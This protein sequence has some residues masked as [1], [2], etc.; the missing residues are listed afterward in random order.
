MERLPRTILIRLEDRDSDRHLFGNPMIWYARY[1]EVSFQRWTTCKRLWSRR[2]AAIV[3]AIN[4][5]LGVT[6]DRENAVAAVIDMVAVHNIVCKKW[7]GD[8]VIPQ[9]RYNEWQGDPFAWETGG[10]QFD[11]AAKI[12]HV[13]YT[14][15]RQIKDNHPLICD[16][17]FV[18]NLAK[19]LERKL[20]LRIRQ[21]CP[22][23]GS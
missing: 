6:D 15:A 18:W 23:H 7:N 10:L 2:M 9:W 21:Q 3:A 13:G 20:T 16:G 19:R 4:I 8:D 11:P 17:D 1:V 22:L 12:D 14:Q 5:V